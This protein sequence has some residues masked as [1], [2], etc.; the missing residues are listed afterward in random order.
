MRM[1]RNPRN[2]RSTRMWLR[3]TANPFVVGSS[4][5]PVFDDRISYWNDENPT[6]SVTEPRTRMQI[7]IKSVSAHAAASCECR[8]PLLILGHGLATGMRT[9]TAIGIEAP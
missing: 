1:S 3:R 2:W 5:T 7:R 9:F 8:L 4:P 6:G